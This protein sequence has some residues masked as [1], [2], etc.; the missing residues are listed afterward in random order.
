[1]DFS[2]NRGTPKW[3]VKIMENPIKDGMIWGV[4]FPYFWKH[5]YGLMDFKLLPTVR[6]E[7]KIF[8]LVVR[9]GFGS[10]QM[11]SGSQE[12]ATN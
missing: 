5:P 9:N 10:S 7:A 2:K 6:V 11:I 8:G 12:N 4:C 1:M 3:M